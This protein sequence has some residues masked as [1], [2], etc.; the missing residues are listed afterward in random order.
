M[1][2]SGKSIVIEGREPIGVAAMLGHT[3][4][5]SWIAAGLVSR[6]FKELLKD[7]A[8][9]AKVYLKRRNKF[10]VEAEGNGGVEK[11]DVEGAV[12]SKILESVKGA[13][14]SRE[15]RAIRFRAALDGSKGVVGVEVASGPGGA[16]TGDE[17]VVCLV[18]GGLHSSVVAWMCLLNGYKVTLVHAELNQRSV[19]EAARLYS[20][21][22]HRTY[23]RGLELQVLKGKSPPGELNRVA[24]SSK[25]PVFGGFHRGAPGPKFLGGRVVSPLY[26]LSEERFESEF[27]A[28]SLQGYDAKMKWDNLVG[29]DMKVKSF[30]GVTAD[31]S[32]VVDG[33]A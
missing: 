25:L 24:R 6:S 16:P 9:L 28:L 7:S 17:G 19:L 29:G 26:V 11:S 14:A 2:R 4:G 3:P 30:G 8:T 15:G 21:L 22:S 20:E 18:S 10:S 5:V 33:L 27:E 12:T 23:P 1:W 13:R 32:E 31:V